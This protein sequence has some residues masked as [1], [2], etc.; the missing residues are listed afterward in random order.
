MSLFETTWLVD[1]LL[2]RGSA[3]KELGQHFLTD[4]AVLDRAVELAEIN[5]NDHVLEIG[6][7]P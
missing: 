1:S 5:E 6:P 7:G 3:L 4:D 2:S